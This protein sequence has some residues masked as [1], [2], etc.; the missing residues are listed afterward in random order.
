M[1]KFKITWRDQDETT[2]EGTELKAHAADYGIFQGQACV[3][4]VPREIVRIVLREKE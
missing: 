4:L 1:A 3:A 2:V